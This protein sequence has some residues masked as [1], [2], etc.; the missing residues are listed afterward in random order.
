MYAVSIPACEAEGM[1]STPVGHPCFATLEPDGRAAACKAADAG[2]IPAGVSSDPPRYC[3][4]GALSAISPA[5]RA[6]ESAL[7]ASLCPA[8]WVVEPIQGGI[9]MRLRWSPLVAA[10]L[11]SA[12]LVSPTRADEPAPVVPAPPAPFL[13]SPT[14]FS[15]VLG[16]VWQRVSEGVPTCRGIGCE[17]SCKTDACQS[18]QAGACPGDGC[19]ASA[20]V[21]V[22]RAVSGAG[23][24]CGEACSCCES[25]KRGESCQ[26][27]DSC[28]CAT[29]K[30]AACQDAC[31][32]GSCPA[33]QQTAKHGRLEIGLGLQFLPVPGVPMVRA[34]MVPSVDPQTLAHATGAG[35]CP[36]CAN[37]AACRCSPYPCGDCASCCPAGCASP[38][39]S[40][41]LAQCQPGSPCQPGQCQPGQPCPNCPPEQLLALTPASGPQCLPLPVPPPLPGVVYS[42]AIVPS[43]PIMPTSPDDLRVEN[44]TLKAQ[45][46]AIHEQQEERAQM[47]DS[48]AEHLV[49]NAALEAKVEAMEA[50]FEGQTEALEQLADQAIENATLTTKLE[51]LEALLEAHAEVAKLT[52]ANAALEAR[53]EAQEALA[54][55]QREHAIELATL[56]AQLEQRTAAAPVERR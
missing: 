51:A 12:C 27:G 2:S 25:G 19:Q 23:C 15:W 32:S 33:P 4:G 53:L 29:A 1:G 49:K 17:A 3:R 43:A 37:E 22:C 16:D 5:R 31:N 40:A 38:C 14:S 30:I 56:K 41:A 7:A 28:A 18:C 6:E 9:L 8:T 55:Q 45:L 46:A 36:P 21:A 35:E 24:K 54:A 26:C 44:A 13:T 10:A 47:F 11:L 48:F 50:I 39:G 52:A 20:L 42:T 34:V